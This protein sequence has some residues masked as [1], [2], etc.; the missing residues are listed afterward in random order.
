MFFEHI[1]YLIILVLIIWIIHFLFHYCFIKS[2]VKEENK[3]GVIL[4][5]ISG[6]FLFV[7]ITCVS[8]FY[9]FIVLIYK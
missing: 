2:I 3:N 9:D 7:G 6:Y 5:Y 4:M 8:L 1:F